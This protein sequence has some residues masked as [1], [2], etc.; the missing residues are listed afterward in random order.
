MKYLN[1][2]ACYSI[3]ILS[4][5]CSSTIVRSASTG[6]ARRLR[7]MLVRSFSDEAVIPFLRSLV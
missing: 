3:K 1:R 7:A 6:N 5:S 2:N 4:P